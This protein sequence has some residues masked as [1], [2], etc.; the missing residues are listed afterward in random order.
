MLTLATTSTA[1]ASAALPSRNRVAVCPL[2][3]VTA[4]KLKAPVVVL[5]LANDGAAPS[6]LKP[7]TFATEQAELPL[8]PVQGSAV[9]TRP[10]ISSP[11]AATVKVPVFRGEYQTSFMTAVVY[12]PS[13]HIWL[14]K[15]REV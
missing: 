10:E 11:A 12:P 4:V 7:T 3:M 9:Q 2:E 5:Q 1:E 13:T 8:V 15:T 14:L 6:T